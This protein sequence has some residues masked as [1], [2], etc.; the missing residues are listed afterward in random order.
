MLL[1]V[2]ICTCGYAGIDRVSRMSL[3]E[4]DGVRYVV[5]WQISEDRSSLMVPRALRRRDVSIFVSDTEGLSRNRNAAL[6]NSY[7]DI[8]LIADDDLNYTAARLNSVMAV[9]ESDTSLD[10]AAFMYDGGETEK[11]YPRD[12]CDLHNVCKGW[13]LTSF[14]LAFR[15][16]RIG[17]LRFNELFGLGAPV[18]E[19]GE[20][21][22]FLF[23]ALKRGLK[24][25]FFPI[26]ITRHNGPTTGVRRVAEPGVL[27]SKGAYMYVAHRS[28][29]LLRIVLN[30]WREMRAGRM[31]FWHA[32]RHGVRG[33]IYAYHMGVKG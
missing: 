29:A 30:A 18:L 20:E 28:T 1:D 26:V 15:R 16:K 7:A 22:L 23:S 32:L 5:S 14:E 33:L 13:Y 24:G 12:E 8:C 9:F 3:P 19:A 11:V 4:V 31:G 6:R 21:N 2:L 17:E 27:M 25:R 10:I